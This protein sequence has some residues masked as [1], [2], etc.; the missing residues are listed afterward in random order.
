MGTFLEDARLAQRRLTDPN[1]V[2]PQEE[3]DNL[4]FQDF[5]VGGQ[6]AGELKGLP[7]FLSSIISETGGAGG[8]AVGAAAGSIIPG[9]GTITGGIIGA[10][11]GGFLGAGGGRL[12]EQQIRDKGKL[13]PGAAF[14][15]GLLSGGFSA[16]GQG[17]QALRG[18]HK[19]AKLSKNVGTLD[20]LS[21]M[22]KVGKG[23]SQAP[24]AL[25]KAATLGDD[26]VNLVDDGIFDVISNSPA[27]I[28]KKSKAAKLVV[29]SM[30]GPARKK[31]LVAAQKHNLL[32]DFGRKISRLATA[33]G[34]STSKSIRGKL[35]DASIRGYFNM[36]DSNIRLIKERGRNPIEIGRKTM[37]L[38]GKTYDDFLGPD[39]LRGK[40][41]LVQD[42][43]TDLG[44]EIGGRLNPRNTIDLNPFYK[45]MAS[46]AAK[47]RISPSL[48]Q[49]KRAD[50]IDEALNFAQ[51][52][53]GEVL[54]EKHAWQIKRSIDD[55]FGKAVSV[56]TDKEAVAS[57]FDKDLA[58]FLRGAIKNV[59]PSV[60]R[61]MQDYQDF[62]FA[63]G[64][65]IGARNATQG[66]IRSP[67]RG[68]SFSNVVNNIFRQ[69]SISGATARATSGVKATAIDEGLGRAGDI[70][71]TAGLRHRAVPQ[72]LQT[73]FNDPSEKQEARVFDPSTFSVD[74]PSEEEQLQAD[75]DFIQQLINQ[76]A[77]QAQNPLATLGVS[78]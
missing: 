5:K 75:R 68:V 4:R 19:V 46:K 12:M 31:A 77:A 21:L 33:E 36:K 18:A 2:E 73:L 48:S 61:P 1:F 39:I 52:N 64:L 55:I 42:K 43:L 67:L 70:I 8:A 57:A 3:E 72:F 69:P 9:V 56:A 44:Q 63:Q 34:A 76:Q 41:G 26:A 6:T 58:N 45:R 14:K 15:E 11:L 25:G 28:A 10:G 27:D 49:A 38:G 47:F 66:G 17:F 23:A 54:D 7:G 60:I 78:R 65:L 35:S 37:Q 74:E 40:G 50:A 29:N 62:K 59:N 51:K 16:A 24:G 20:A 32:D 22:N 53:I 71:G 13:D 30:S